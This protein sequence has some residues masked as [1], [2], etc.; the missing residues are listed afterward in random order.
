VRQ[1]TYVQ[2]KPT[3]RYFKR[4]SSVY[5]LKNIVN[6]KKKKRTLLMLRNK[7]FYYKNVCRIFICVVSPKYNK[8]YRCVNHS[9]L[10]D[11]SH[12]EVL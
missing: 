11:V 6:K 5:N 3:D 12:P 4:N 2:K 8:Q 1:I 9:E 7:Y 10:F